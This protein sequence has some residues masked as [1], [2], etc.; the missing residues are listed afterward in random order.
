M[1]IGRTALSVEI[2]TKCRPTVDRRISYDLCAKDVAHAS[3]SPPTR[4]FVGSGMK[5]T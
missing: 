2:I 5:I 3:R 4:T 1:L